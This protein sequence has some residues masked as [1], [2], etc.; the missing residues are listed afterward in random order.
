MKTFTRINTSLRRLLPILCIFIFSIQFVIADFS[1]QENVKISDILVDK[2]GTPVELGVVIFNENRGAS[3][4]VILNYA[5]EGEMLKTKC[6]NS[7]EFQNNLTYQKKVYCSIPK[8][9]LNGVYTAYVELINKSTN[10][11]LYNFSKEFFYNSKDQFAITTFKNTQNG[12]VVS[13]DLRYENIS[14]ETIILH[15]I[16]KGVLE[17]ITRDQKDSL[18]QSSKE[19]EIVRENPIISWKVDN[20]DDKIEYTIINKSVN[21]SYKN[22]FKTYPSEDESIT[23]V[24]IF[25]IIVLLIIIFLPLFRKNN[26]KN[27]KSSQTKK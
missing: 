22:Q 7:I 8:Q 21:N 27:E 17:N 26:N 16:P 20:R 6:S 11:K 10:E 19:F 24:V 2:S 5:F 1:Y 18:I 3:F 14:S 9:E 4:D 23:I 13:I 12:T 15:D 25:S